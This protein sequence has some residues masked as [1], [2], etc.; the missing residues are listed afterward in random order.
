MLLFLIELYDSLY[1]TSF[2]DL[3]LL[4][5][6]FIFSVMSTRVWV[7]ETILSMMQN[8]ILVKEMVEAFVD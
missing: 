6:A 4:A 5:K 8:L 3:C 1:R 2:P 7:V